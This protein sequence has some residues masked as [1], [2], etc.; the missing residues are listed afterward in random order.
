MLG[1]GVNEAILWQMQAY[2]AE[3]LKSVQHRPCR[4][5]LVLS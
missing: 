4:V 1:T 3:A 5:L 2:C